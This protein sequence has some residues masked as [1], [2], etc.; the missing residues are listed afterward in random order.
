MLKHLITLITVLVAIS[1]GTANAD[2]AIIAHPDY[3][4][5]ELS[6][7][8]VRALFLSEVASYPSGHKADFVNHAAGSVDRKHFFEYVLSMGETRHRRYW[9]RKAAVGKQ[10]LPK[11]LNSHKEVLAWVAKTPLGIA[12]I[13]KDKVDDTVKVLLTVNVYEEL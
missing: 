7:D 12:Y 13:N 10:G 4:G 2:L 3:K 6:K 8:M 5:G 11:E 9:S 1:Y